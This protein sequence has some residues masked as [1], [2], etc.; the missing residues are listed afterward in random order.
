[1]KNPP[2]FIQGPG[3]MVKTIAVAR[4]GDKSGDIEVERIAFD[5]WRILMG[6]EVNTDGLK[7]RLLPERG[8]KIQFVSVWKT[9]AQQHNPGQGKIGVAQPF[10]GFAQAVREEARVPYAGI[11]KGLADFSQMLGI[12]LNNENMDV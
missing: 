8:K 10:T 11:L 12:T 9:L 1:M 3:Q 2:E 6:K 7:H 5:L 4:F